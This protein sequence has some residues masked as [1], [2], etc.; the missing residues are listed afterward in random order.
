[1]LELEVISQNEMKIF[2]KIGF[3]LFFYVIFFCGTAYHFNSIFEN[4][5]PSRLGTGR[6]GSGHGIVSSLLPVRHLRHFRRHH[7]NQTV[8]IRKEGVKYVLIRRCKRFHDK[9]LYKYHKI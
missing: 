1:M 7:T 3:F 6:D 4:P 5:V 9:K 2:Y 8:E